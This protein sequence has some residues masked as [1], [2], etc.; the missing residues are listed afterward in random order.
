MAADDIWGVPNPYAT[1][2][3]PYRYRV[4]VS[5]EPAGHTYTSFQHAAS[6]AE[7]LATGRRARVIY[8]EGD[9][10]TLLADYRY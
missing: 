5:P 7:E 4:R 3:L 8:I 6:A 9:S 10:P 1:V 2:A